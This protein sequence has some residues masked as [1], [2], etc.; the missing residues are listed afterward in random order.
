[1]KTVRRTGRPLA[2][3]LIELIVVLVILGILAALAIPTFSA[4]RNAGGQTVALSSA[5]NIASNASALWGLYDGEVGATIGDTTVSCQNKCAQEEILEA[6]VLDTGL[7][8]PQTEGSLQVETM[9][10]TGESV[11]MLVKGAAGTDNEKC[12][13][14]TFADQKFIAADKACPAA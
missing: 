11:K 10:G 8:Y 14:I 2:F 6:A 4:I 5:T 12:A 13:E 3:T 7:E 9:T 1:M